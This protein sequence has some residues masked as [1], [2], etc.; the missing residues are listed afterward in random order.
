MRKLIHIV[1]E[2]VERGNPYT[3]IDIFFHFSKNSFSI[4]EKS[5][6][7]N[8]LLTCQT[9]TYILRPSLGGGD[10]HILYVHVKNTTFLNR[11]SSFKIY[12]KYQKYALELDFILFLL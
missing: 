2:S 1:V 6:F 9:T 12:L 11:I 7:K 3:V 10:F 8:K 4:G 5:I